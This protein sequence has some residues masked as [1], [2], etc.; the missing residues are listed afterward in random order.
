MDRQPLGG[1]SEPVPLID[2]GTALD[3]LVAAVEHRG[4]DFVYQPVW[5]DESRYL[6]C[7]YANRG[8]PD[9]IVGQAL[10]FA[11]IGAHDLE[12]L[13]DD[14]LQEL[15]LRGELPV[16]L[17]LGALTVFRAAQ[18]SQDRGC[19]WGDVLA[20]AAA[21]AARFIDL[22]PDAGFD[23]TNRST[24]GAFADLRGSLSDDRGPEHRDVRPEPSQ[25]R[26]APTSARPFLPDVVVRIPS[27]AG[28]AEA[29]PRIT[30]R[31]HATPADR[32]SGLR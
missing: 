23:V 5:V 28:R 29:R 11:D 27:Q 6:T 10:A 16:T 26:P 8:A 18:L 13:S 7:R 9:C 15:Y 31:T 14:G 17:T 2:I 12:A 3:L 24:E 1:L 21:V 19:P 22:L 32:R 25:G 4:T 20:Y 30:A